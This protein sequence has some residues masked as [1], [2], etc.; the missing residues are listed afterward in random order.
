[1]IHT[2]GET[3]HKGGKPYG[4]QQNNQ[5]A[6]NGKGMVI[7]NAGRARLCQPADCFQLGNGKKLSRCAQP[8][9]PE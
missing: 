5:K 2:A 6:Q 1:M 8:A 3:R 9:A 4:T 7:G